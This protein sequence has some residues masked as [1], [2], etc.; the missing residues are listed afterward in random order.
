MQ[1]QTFRY[2]FGVS[3]FGSIIRFLGVLGYKKVKVSSPLPEDTG[4]IIAS[5][6][7]SLTDPLCIA[8]S[9]RLKRPIRWIAKKECQYGK[10]VA[11]DLKKIGMPTPLAYILGYIGAW[12]VR[13]FLAF[14]VDR[15]NKNSPETVLAIRSAINALSDGGVVGIFPEGTASKEHK[16]QRKYGGKKGVYLLAKMSGR[17]VIPVW[18]DKK[19]IIFGPPIDYRED[20]TE[21]EFVDKVIASYK[22]L[23]PKN[24]T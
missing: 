22:A 12:F 7:G 8:T 20:W 11:K 6:H 21:K 16:E 4:F 2:Y 10:G 18:I 17:P 1:K 13:G 23:G 9:L 15:D 19:D 24:A 14:F 3:I 5:R